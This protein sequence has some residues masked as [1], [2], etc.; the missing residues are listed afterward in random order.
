MMASSVEKIWT[1]HLDHL[2][3]EAIALPRP[4]THTVATVV[5]S[6]NKL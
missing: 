3:R 1:S 6:D 5:K 4:Y 2:E